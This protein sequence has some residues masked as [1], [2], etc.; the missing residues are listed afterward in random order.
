MCD[1]GLVIN[2]NVYN[3]LPD[4]LK[5]ILEEC[6]TEMEASQRQLFC[7]LETGYY[8]QLVE[9]G[10]VFTPADLAKAKE[11][12]SDYVTGFLGDNEVRNELYDLVQQDIAS[13]K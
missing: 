13:V 11:L 2:K 3:S 1:C 6:V 12:V 8:D 5:A 7:D 10:V 9:F 4:D